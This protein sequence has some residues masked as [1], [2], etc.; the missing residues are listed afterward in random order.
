MGSL[1][2]RVASRF[3]A[4]KRVGDVVLVAGF[5][6]RFLNRRG[7]VSDELAARLGAPSSSGGA[8]ISVSEMALVGAAA[9]RLI[10]GMRNR[11][12]A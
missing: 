6:L 10:R 8:G 11:R 7:L 2:N 1:P 9:L 5:V 4:L 3:P 12:A